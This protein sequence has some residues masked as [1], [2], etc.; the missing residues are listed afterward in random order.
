MFVANT[1]P[2]VIDNVNVCRGVAMA[3]HY[4]I[5]VTFL[6]MGVEAVYMHQTLI[7]VFRSG[8]TTSFMTKSIIVAWG[9]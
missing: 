4:I 1:I 9:M 7:K 2:A 5:L 8:G 6:W 3:M